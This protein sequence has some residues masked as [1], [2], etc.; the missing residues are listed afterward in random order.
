[1]S[2]SG[3]NYARAL[4]TARE[5]SFSSLEE[6]NLKEVAFKSGAVFEDPIL[7]LPFLNRM[8]VVD[9]KQRR[10]R[11]DTEEMEIRTAILILHYL[12]RASGKPL[13]GRLIG[14][15]EAP[16]GGLYFQPFRNRVVLPVLGLLEKKPEIVRRRIQELGGKWL[17]EADL[18]F[19]LQIFPYVILQYRFY[20]GEEGIPP[21]LNILFDSSIPEYLST[22]DIVVLCETT[23]RAL[24]SGLPKS[25]AP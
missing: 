10:I 16:Q 8:T 25:F 7:K 5:T 9:V 6:K 11:I 18:G 4:L 22:E 20:R 17:D 21:D 23:N 3:N 12:L 2:G 13:T 15:K 24:K 14:F 19:R 1:M